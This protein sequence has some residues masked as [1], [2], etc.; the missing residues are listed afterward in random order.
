[1][2]MIALASDRR[3]SAVT[4]AALVVFALAIT[5]G[6]LTADLDGERT[7]TLKNAV[8]NQRVVVDSGLPTSKTH[9]QKNKDEVSVLV[10]GREHRENVLVPCMKTLRQHVV[11]PLET[12]EFRVSTYICVEKMTETTRK[13]IEQYINVS[14]VF[15]YNSP[16]QF[17]RAHE[18]F[19]RVTQS[20][21]EML[22]RVKYFFKARPDMM[23]LNDITLPFHQDAI[24]L[25]ARRISRGKVT[26]Q[27]L[28]WQ[29]GPREECKCA[30]AGCVMV[31]SMVAVVPKPWADA[32]FKLDLNTTS[33][34]F[35]RGRER[36]DDIDKD[37]DK[38]FRLTSDWGNRCPCATEWD[39]GTLTLRLASHEAFVFI[40]PFNFVLAPPM[41]GSAAWR[42]GGT[43]V[44][45]DDDWE[46]C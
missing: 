32:Y 14:D 35:P 28:S 33:K 12:R 3:T 19:E 13:H 23:W 39:E 25:R 37:D 40:S 16:D 44:R 9:Q 29:V 30:D 42:A 10:I 41:P 46:T 8:R 26:S 31:D 45:D 20:S 36:L 6:T 7:V 22:S 18:C 15:E 1:M 17:S 4:L 24:M 5:R 2:M 27:H 43:Y 11:A 38:L 34:I 21:P